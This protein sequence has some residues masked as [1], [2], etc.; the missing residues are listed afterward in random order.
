ME[1]KYKLTFVESVY[2]NTVTQTVE[3]TWKE[4]LQCI[5][6]H[7]TILNKTDAMMVLPCSFLDTG[8][9]YE[10]AYHKKPNNKKINYRNDGE[11]HIR[12]CAKNVK[13]VYMLFLD[14]D[15][16]MVLSEAKEL[17]KEYQ[18]LG[19]TSSGHKTKRKN[20]K[21]AFRIILPF[22]HPISNTQYTLRGKSIVKWLGADLDQSSVDV[23]RGFFIPS[24]EQKDAKN[25]HEI[26]SNEG[27]LLN[28]LQFDEEESVEYN[29][30]QSKFS[31]GLTI[32]DMDGR[33]Y[34]ILWNTLDV[35]ALFSDLDLYIG[36]DNNNRHFVHCPWEK[37]HST[38]SSGTVIY[39]ANKDYPPAFSCLHGHCRDK[40]L[41][42]F[43]QFL[44]KDQEY[45]VEYL[46]QFFEVVPKKQHL[47][48]MIAELRGKLENKKESK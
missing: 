44:M 34:D 46:S 27:R 10:Y 12:R 22:K 3:Y 35:V 5:N 24:Y 43:T 13:M 37:S 1:N 42:D 39:E 16:E 28:P 26:W 47:Q 30:I 29:K 31:S 9:S 38:D 45:G 6:K 36:E 8:D 20:Y 21:D 23:A 2:D 11:P 25:E 4:F 48:E 33:D 17:F 41:Y 14:F 19:Y 40:K 7:T 18:Y 32:G 15:G